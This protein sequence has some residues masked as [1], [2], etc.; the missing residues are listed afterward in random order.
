MAGIYFR[1]VDLN[2]SVKLYGSD[3]IE[4]RGCH[5]KK[6]SG[7]VILPTLRKYGYNIRLARVSVL[8]PFVFL[9]TKLDFFKV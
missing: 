3:K 1:T 4:D 9:W 7:S 2:S 8:V 6:Q 5:R